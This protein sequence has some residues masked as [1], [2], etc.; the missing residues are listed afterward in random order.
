MKC[1]GAEWVYA[2]LFGGC[3]KI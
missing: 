3:T 2:N 1:G